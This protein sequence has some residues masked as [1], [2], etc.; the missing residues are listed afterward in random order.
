MKKSVKPFATSL[1]DRNIFLVCLAI[2]QSPST[3]QGLIA[4]WLI[5][6]AWPSTATTFLAPA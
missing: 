3:E 4:S 1:H 6:V 5:F 2:F